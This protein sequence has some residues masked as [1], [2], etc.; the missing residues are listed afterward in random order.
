[1]FDYN[2]GNKKDQKEKKRGDKLRILPL[3]T[4]ICE[5]LS[6]I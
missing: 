4:I 1:M 5:L 6:F 3:I 2:S